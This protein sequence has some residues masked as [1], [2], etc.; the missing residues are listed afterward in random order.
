MEIRKIKLDEI[1]KLSTLYNHLDFEEFKRQ[2]INEI[3]N[4]KKDVYVISKDNELIGEI[5]VFYNL[6][7]IA[8][9]K[10]LRVYLNAFRI[11]KEF[12]NQGLGQEL[13]KYVIN[14][15]ESKGITEFTIGVENDNEIAKHIYEKYDFTEIIDRRE[16]KNNKEIYEYNLLLKKSNNKKIEKLIY[17]FNLANKIQS[18]TQ[19]HGGLSN[20]MYK[21]VT[22]K[23]NYAIKKLNKSLMQSEESFERILFAEEVS[24]IAQENGVLVERA[25]M[26]DGNIIHQI[27]NDYY[28]IFNWNKGHHIKPEDVNEQIC[29]KIG[30]LLADIH[31]IDFSNTSIKKE[32]NIEIR[33]INWDYYIEIA[34]S[35]RKFY[36]EELE[37]NK[38]I[39]YELNK[40]INEALEYSKDNLIISHRDLI[41][42]NILWNDNIP[43]IIDWEAS[44]YINPTVELVQVCWNWANGDVGAFDFEKF[45]IIIKEY[46]KYVKN[47]KKEDM[48]KLIYA[49]FWEAI[50]WL[51]YN[52]KRS[53]CIENSYRK[54]EIE[55]AEK[56]ICYLNDEIK[57]AMLQIESVAKYLNM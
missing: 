45:Q 33:T 25:L 17:K 46:L 40:K 21:V 1:E 16:E 39:L 8:T 12:Q 37:K 31:N 22:D 14:D 13:L 57:Y 43:T 23:S 50:E 52:L 10:N 42:K 48:E 6:D 2:L 29:I 44:G 55:L 7:Y 9:I 53:L 15:L 51:E 19:I 36:S 47:Y 41:K 24:K 32:K 30:K 5:T 4:H 26:L 56:E 11:K 38:D 49:N 27:D 3:L 20:R 28:M 35:E 54:E 34:K 18:I